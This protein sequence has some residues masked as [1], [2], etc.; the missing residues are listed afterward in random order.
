MEK[1]TGIFASGRRFF[2]GCNYWA[3]HAGTAM[4][5]QWQ[6]ET[7]EADLALLQKNRIE[8]LR[9]FPLW[10]DF[11]PLVRETRWC[12]TGGELRLAGGLP[13][14][15]TAAGRAGVDETM[16]ARFR[17][18]AELAN[19]YDLKLIVGLVTGW[20]SG[21]MHVPPAFEGVNVLTDPEAVRWEVKLVRFL[22]RSLRDC[23]AIVAWDL[24]NECNC[25]ALLEHAPDAA[26]LWSDTITAAVK[27]EDAGRPVVS[28][29]HS[30]VCYADGNSW[31]IAGQ[32]ET[33]D[34][35]TTHPYPLFTPGCALDPIH[36]MR[37][38]F[39]ATAET[40]LYGDVGGVPAFIEEAGT[41]GPGVSSDRVAGRYMR[42]LLWN[43]WAHDC[44]GMLWWCAF[45]Q[46]DLAQTPYDWMAIERELGLIR[47]DGG[48]KPALLELKQFAELLD[49]ANL[50]QLPPFRR[51]AVVILTPGQD[52]WLAAY[53]CFLLAKQAGFDVE[54]QTAEQPLKPSAFYLMPSIAGPAGMP[55]H[56]YLALL[57]KVRQG[58]TLLVSSDAG[59]LQPCN[60]AFGIDIEYTA[61]AT[62]PVTVRSEAFQFDC[63]ARTLVKLSCRGA[64]T[65]AVD[66]DGDPVFTCH[67]HGNGK[68]LFLAVPLELAAATTPRMFLPEAPPC[69]R[70]YQLAAELAGVVRLV[71]R[72]NRSLTLTEH[73]A[74]PDEL[75]VVAV[76][77]TP[78]PLTDRLTAAAGWHFDSMAYGAPPENERWTIPGNSGSVLRF[79]K[80]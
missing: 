16:V 59:I 43:A 32:A 5:R 46:G 49:R 34:V 3:S 74:A 45:D 47:R 52:N 17:R 68:L 19:R 53:A 62:A 51:D 1:P 66:G 76:N 21:R 9:V 58:A 11:Q 25:M 18:L 29:M 27:R 78:E 14:P 30:L 40:R 64:Q 63:P 20:M 7:V 33:T 42:N 22:V 57:E 23:P 67:R 10:P 31:T 44:R 15:D 39:H 28:G 77:N 41:L 24:G 61:A 70:L 37:N 13:L 26:W 35:L 69:Y 75:L 48:G 38:V 72:T 71:T 79:R 65:L 55:R 56:R 73:S 4:W 8:T 12:Q 60:E 36:T 6:P 80:K 2:V 50:R 54:F